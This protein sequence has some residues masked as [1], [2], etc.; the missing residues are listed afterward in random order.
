MRL[1]KPRCPRHHQ[2]TY[3]RRGLRF[4]GLR[5]RARLS[6]FT[7]QGGPGGKKI[8]ISLPALPTT[9]A[10]RQRPPSV[11]IPPHDIPI[12]SGDTPRHPIFSR[13]PPPPPIP[14]PTRAS[15]GNHRHRA[16]GGSHPIRQKGEKSR[17]RS[18]PPPPQ[19]PALA[20]S[21]WGLSDLLRG[22]RRRRLLRDP[23]L[24]PPG[25]IPQRLRQQA[26]LSSGTGGERLHRLPQKRPL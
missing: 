1:G 25:Q 12:N 23:D 14:G 4:L 22:C 7:A 26:H 13:P 9:P 10:K 5:A 16:T 24:D 3:P 8:A 6:P 17:P 20:I 21:A 19:A 15:A 18:R 11:T 2:G